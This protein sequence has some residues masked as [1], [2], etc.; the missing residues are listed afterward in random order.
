MKHATDLGDEN[1]ILYLPT[2]G[3]CAIFVGLWWAGP[4]TRVGLVQGLQSIR[5]GVSSAWRL[6]GIMSCS[7]RLHDLVICVTLMLGWQ[8]G[9]IFRLGHCGVFVANCISLIGLWVGMWRTQKIVCC[10]GG[11]SM[12]GIYMCWKRRF[13]ANSWLLTL[14]L[15]GDWWTSWGYNLFQPPHTLSPQQRVLHFPLQRFLLNKPLYTLSPI[16]RSKFP[17]LPPSWH[18]SLIFPLFL[19]LNSHPLNS[20][21]EVLELQLW[22]FNRLFLKLV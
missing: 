2:T 20:L 11:P 4:L 5:V 13:A 8:C 3:A 19:P 22:N 15:I 9:I 21:R 14:P 1:M 6:G 18:T 7:R 16:F 12:F 17:L 10:Y